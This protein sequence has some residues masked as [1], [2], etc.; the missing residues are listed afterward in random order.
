MNKRPKYILK[1][2]VNVSRNNWQSSVHNQRMNIAL[3]ELRCLFCTQN[4]VSSMQSIYKD[5][6]LLYIQSFVLY[7]TILTVTALNHVSFNTPIQNK[8]KNIIY[9]T[10]HD[11]WCW[12]Q[13]ISCTAQS[14]K[15][16]VIAAGEGISEK[17]VSQIVLRRNHQEG[18]P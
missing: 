4:H 13:S 17:A 15:Q 7:C 6:V 10:R 1:K 8:V 11:V 5:W 9:V 12:F 3:W 2:I 16:N 14:F 18:L